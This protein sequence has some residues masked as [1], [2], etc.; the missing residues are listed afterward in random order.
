[1]CLAEIITT[2]SPCSSST[3]LTS[4]F[5]LRINV[6]TGCIGYSIDTNF[7][8]LVQGYTAHYQG[9]VVVAAGQHD[10]SNIIVGPVLVVGQSAPTTVLQPNWQVPGMYLQVLANNAW[11]AGKHTDTDS[12][13]NAL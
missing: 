8:T 4:A 5:Q 9:G 12:Q 2:N 13:R 1:L 11:C 10:T 7:P 6:T 3:N